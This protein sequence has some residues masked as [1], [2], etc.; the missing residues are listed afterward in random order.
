MKKI[1][2]L[3]IISAIILG[4]IAPV[5]AVESLKG[6]GSLGAAVSIGHD[7]FSSDGETLQETDS[8]M[9]MGSLGYFFTD[10]FEINY[11][12]MITYRETTSNWSDEEEKSDSTM[13]SHLLNLKYNFYGKGWKLIPYLGI[14]GGFAGFTSDDRSDSAFSYGGMGGAKVFVSEDVS[15]NLELNH[16][17]TQYPGEDNE[18]DSDFASTTFL[19]G[20]TFY[21]GGGKAE[22][23]VVRNEEIEESDIEEPYESKPGIP[24]PAAEP[25]KKRYSP[26][27]EIVLEVSNFPGNRYDWISIATP[28]SENTDYETYSYIGED[29]K[30]GT[31]SL[32]G[33]EAGQYEIRY[34]YNWENG[35]YDYRVLGYLNIGE[36]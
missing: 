18:P 26:Y 2:V 17:I 21:F 19:L 23:S 13:Y 5:W 25:S 36:K 33:I 8:G 28:G 32:S 20:L 1:F 3:F 35:Q 29:M 30:N 24:G 34:Y 16:I 4:A 7:S 9:V 10:H 12:P 15:I 22:T 14:Q 11:A 6:R 31:I 27:E